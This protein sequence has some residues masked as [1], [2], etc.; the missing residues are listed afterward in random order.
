VSNDVTVVIPVFNSQGTIERALESVYLQTKAP[1]EVIVVDDCSSDDYTTTFVYWESRF[2]SIGVE[3]RTIRLQ[4][5]SGPSRARNIGWNAATTE[6]IAFLDADDSWLCRKLEV[7]LQSMAVNNF[8]VVGCFS[9]RVMHRAMHTRCSKP[10]TFLKFRS[11]LLRNPFTTCSTVLLRTSLPFRFN[12]AMRYAEDYDLWLR[13]SGVGLKLGM[14]NEKLSE[15]HK[16]LYG[17]AG[18][19]GDILLMQIHEL[20]CFRRLRRDGFINRAVYLFLISF[21]FSKFLKRVLLHGI[22]KLYR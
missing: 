4:R 2:S 1:Y 15:Y 18:L 19:S 16:V 6:F 22:F 5:N 7:Q 13:M 12:E 20:A 8:D 10:A 17:D 11:I 9:G 3:F 21:S 14:V